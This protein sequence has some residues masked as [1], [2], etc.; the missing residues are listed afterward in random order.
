VARRDIGEPRPHIG[1]PRRVQPRCVAFDPHEPRPGRGEAQR[2]ARVVRLFDHRGVAGIEQHPRRE[3]DALLRAV[4]DDD[5]LRVARQAARAVEVLGQ[6]LAQRC[7]AGRRGVAEGFAPSAP[8]ARREQPP[9]D[10]ARKLVDRRTPVAEVVAQPGPADVRTRWRH[11]RIPGQAPRVRGD[12][13]RDL[14]HRVVRRRRG[15][16]RHCRGHR[17]GRATA[18]DDVALGEQLLVREHDRVARYAEIR[19]ERAGRRQARRGGEAPGVDVGLERMVD[20]AVERPGPAQVEEHLAPS[21]KEKL[22]L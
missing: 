17:R 9:P 11:R 12:L 19:G 6:R 4:D 20:A 3:F 10:L 7:V 21:I 16:S 14:V 13:R 22:A 1:E 2:G 15:A 18:A 5:L 8:C